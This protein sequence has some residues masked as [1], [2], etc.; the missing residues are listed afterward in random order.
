MHYAVEGAALAHD[1]QRCNRRR[2]LLFKKQ[3]AQR[4][5]DDTSTLVV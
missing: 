1:R 2:S 5:A 4:A 3:Q